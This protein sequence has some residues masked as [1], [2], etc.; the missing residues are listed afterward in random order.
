MR[1]GRGAGC[2]VRPARPV[3]V[4]ASRNVPGLTLASSRSEVRMF[5]CKP[6][7]LAGLCKT[8]CT[9]LSQML[10]PDSCELLT[11]M[12]GQLVQEAPCQANRSCRLSFRDQIE[13]AAQHARNRTGTSIFRF[14]TILPQFE[15]SL[16][17]LDDQTL[18]A[19]LS[20]GIRRQL[21]DF[22]SANILCLTFARSAISKLCKRL[23]CPPCR[24]VDT[25]NLHRTEDNTSVH[26]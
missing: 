1:A 24:L 20:D 6:A 15:L 7:C 4:L 23:S 3:G 8:T 17:T 16:A 10:Q 13:S 21:C 11:S 26:A 12:L 25:N 9:G 2:V 18:Y 19:L 5:R 14:P 22:D